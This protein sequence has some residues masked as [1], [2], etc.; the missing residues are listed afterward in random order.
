MLA[1]GRKIGGKTSAGDDSRA[2]TLG[3]TLGVI[4]GWIGSEIDSGAI[5]VLV[6]ESVFDSVIWDF[7]MGRWMYM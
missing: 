3:S 6:V 1:T 4:M 7:Y 5:V 2:S